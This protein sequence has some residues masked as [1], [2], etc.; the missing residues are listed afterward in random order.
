MGRKVWLW[1]IA[2]LAILL[3]LAVTAVIVLSML[4]GDAPTPEVPDSSQEQTKDQEPAP[5]EQG[6]TEGT[7][8]EDATTEATEPATQ[9]A[10]EPAEQPTEEPAQP[11]EEATQDAGPDVGANETP[12]G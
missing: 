8:A 1:I 5:S 9:T 7:K 4:G 11:T 2:G 6:T 3:A 10:T 12:W